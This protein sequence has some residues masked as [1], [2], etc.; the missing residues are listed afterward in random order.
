MKNNLTI[1]VLSLTL[2]IITFAVPDDAQAQVSPNCDGTSYDC[3]AL[4]MTPYAYRRIQTC[5][6]KPWKLACRRG[7]A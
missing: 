7:I 5:G 6:A 1:Y 3:M 4:L 2:A